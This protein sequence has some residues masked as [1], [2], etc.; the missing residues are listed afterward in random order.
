MWKLS[1]SLLIHLCAFLHKYL[2]DNMVDPHQS[3]HHHLYPSNNL[4]GDEGSDI[5]HLVLDHH[6]VHGLSLYLKYNTDL[7]LRQECSHNVMKMYFI[8]LNIY[9]DRWQYSSQSLQCHA[10]KCLKCAHIR[11]VALL[12][13]MCKCYH[14][15]TFSSK[16]DSS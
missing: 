1:K 9:A 14:K 16:L 3:R 11:H 2:C 7:P 6:M 13:L 12:Q 15:G 4:V 5:L 8:F 10:L